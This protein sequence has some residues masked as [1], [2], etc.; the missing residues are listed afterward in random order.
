MLENAGFAVCGYSGYDEQPE[1]GR[2]HILCFV[3]KKCG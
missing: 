3:A 2:S 1:D